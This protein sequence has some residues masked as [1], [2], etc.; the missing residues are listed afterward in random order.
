LTFHQNR[1]EVC[2]HA[3]EIIELYEQGYSGNDIAEELGLSASS[4]LTLLR[5]RG[6]IRTLSESVNM[7]VE[8]GKMVNDPDLEV[9]EDLAWLIGA[10]YC[11]GSCFKNSSGDYIVSLYAVDKEFVDSFVRRIEEI[12]LACDRNITEPDEEG[13]NDLYEAKAYS[14]RF[15]EWWEDLDKDR[16]EE[17]ASKY[18]ASFVGGFYDSD[19]SLSRRNG[20]WNV[21]IRRND[22]WL[23]ELVCDLVS[24][25]IGVEFLDIYESENSKVIS[26]LKQEDVEEFSEWVNNSISRK[27]ISGHPEGCRK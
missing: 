22:R 12:G 3:D 8:Q 6:K 23:L 26:L 1:S 25:N 11:D 24:E 16:I 9:T 13:W 17:I 27:S 14:K 15:Y 18:P 5:E 10:I 20:N 21:R 4:I 19:G 7:A 2:K